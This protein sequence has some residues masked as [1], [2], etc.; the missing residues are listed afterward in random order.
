MISSANFQ[1]LVHMKTLFMRFPT[2]LQASEC[3]IE[4]LRGQYAHSVGCYDEA[5]FH[6]IEAAK[7]YIRYVYKIKVKKF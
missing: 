4:M 3:I 6:Y 7:V 5:T 1:A 2:I